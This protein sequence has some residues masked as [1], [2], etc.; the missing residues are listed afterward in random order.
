MIQ[1]TCLHFK[2]HVMCCYFVR[3]ENVS[4]KSGEHLQVKAI[5]PSHLAAHSA[6]LF[7]GYRFLFKERIQAPAVL[8]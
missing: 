5:S 1:N 3:V 2:I 8:E 4:G 7:T 6:T